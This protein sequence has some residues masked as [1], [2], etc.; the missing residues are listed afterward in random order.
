MAN[1]KRKDTLSKRS[2]S[3]SQ[4]NLTEIQDLIRLMKDQEI[5][6]LSYE[7]KGQK[8]SIKTNSAF[9]APIQSAAAAPSSSLAPQVSA[10]ASGVQSETVASVLEENFHKKILSPF[11]GTFYRSPSPE[12]DVYVKEGVS[13]KPGDVLCIVEA[14]KLM[15]EIQSEYAGKILSILVENGQ[16][17]EF[18]EPLFIVEV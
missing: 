6:E 3:Q 12:S 1:K 7:V 15:N 5:A 10:L 18:G 16:P 4:V 13:V 17:V 2:N 8:L 11:V 14:M 9:P